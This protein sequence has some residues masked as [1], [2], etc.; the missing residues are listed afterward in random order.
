MHKA[1]WAANWWNTLRFY[2][3][4][5]VDDVSEHLGTQ[6]KNVKMNLHKKRLQSYNLDA[7]D[8]EC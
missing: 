4:I 2:K 1:L 8:L 5:N 7:A 3:V 6:H